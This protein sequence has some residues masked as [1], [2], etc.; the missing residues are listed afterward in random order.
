MGLIITTLEIQ[1]INHWGSG[2]YS[3][4]NSK[5]IMKRGDR[6]QMGPAYGEKF[7]KGKEYYLPLKNLKIKN[8]KKTLIRRMF[9]IIMC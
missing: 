8:K 5:M 1:N 4:K 3:S 6:H 9:F 2:F 7:T